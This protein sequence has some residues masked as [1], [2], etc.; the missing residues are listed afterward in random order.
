MIVDVV[1]S[2]CEVRQLLM[3]SLVVL[4]IPGLGL[5]PYLT[6]LLRLKIEKKR[7]RRICQNDHTVLLQP[8]HFVQ[9]RGKILVNRCFMCREDSESTDHLLVHCRVARALWEPT[10]SCL[11]ISWVVSNSIRNHLLAWEVSFVVM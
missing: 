7:A 1:A 8:L 10:F 6:G 4:R 9:R 2:L 11:N 5:F 3:G